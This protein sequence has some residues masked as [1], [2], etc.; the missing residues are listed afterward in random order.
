MQHAPVLGPHRPG[1]SATG[2]ALLAD[3]AQ[4]FLV[5]RQEV[6]ASAGRGHRDRADADVAEHLDEMLVVLRRRI[7]HVALH[8]HP[9]V[10]PAPGRDRVRCDQP[11][12]LFHA[13][14]RADQLPALGRAVP[15]RL[16]RRVERGPG[17]TA[18]IAEELGRLH[19]IGNVF[20]K[21]ARGRLVD[22]R[23][24]EVGRGELVHLPL[25]SMTAAHHD[26]PP[27]RIVV[28]G[29]PADEEVEADHGP[30]HQTARLRVQP[31]G[32]FVALEHLGACGDLLRELPRIAFG[33][34]MELDESLERAGWHGLG[35]LAELG[36]I[37]HPDRPFQSRPVDRHRSRRIAEIRE[38]REDGRGWWVHRRTI[39]PSRRPVFYA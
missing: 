9:I 29:Q 28:L 37:T 20:Q 3:P 11:A 14:G 15:V 22:D 18:V 27:I 16:I 6:E 1:R 12:Q 17:S 8:L 38:K 2:L 26:R 19:V 39:A 13:I 21:R 5:G 4:E 7:T 23:A 33:G 24:Q 34:V 35:D 30:R 10:Q 31:I 25:V 32:Q 36:R